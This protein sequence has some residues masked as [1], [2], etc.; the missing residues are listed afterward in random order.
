ML[1][2]S[3]FFDLLRVF[4]IQDTSDHEDFTKPLETGK[5]TR[6]WMTGP[7]FLAGFV[8]LSRILFVFVAV[9]F[10]DVECQAKNRTV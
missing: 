6:V 2:R 7:D 4:P 8:A 3:S 10:L 9:F 1:L 5:T